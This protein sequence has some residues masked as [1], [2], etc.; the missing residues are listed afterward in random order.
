MYALYCIHCKLLISVDLLLIKTKGK[1]TRLISGANLIVKE[2]KKLGKGVF[3]EELIEKDTIICEYIGERISKYE[4]VKRRIEYVGEG[5]RSNYGFGFENV[6]DVIIDSTKFGNISRYVNS[7]HQ[8]NC[9]V[10]V[11]SR[12]IHSLPFFYLFSFRAY[13]M[14]SM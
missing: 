4:W 3:T 5:I 9:E 12:C 7:S 6:A 8:P 10:I 14:D 13:V 11:V 2:T 1:D